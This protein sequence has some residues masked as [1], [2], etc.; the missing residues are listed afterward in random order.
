MPVNKFTDLSRC[1]GSIAERHTEIYEDQSIHVSLVCS[2][3]DRF[4]C[5]VAVAT[6][7]LLEA[8][9]RKLALDCHLIEAAVVSVEDLTCV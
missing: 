7:V 4:Q 9:L 3:L 6:D 8:K 2:Y 1:S 5:L